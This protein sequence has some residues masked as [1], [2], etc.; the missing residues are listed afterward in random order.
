MPI[1]VKGRTVS[2]VAVVGSGNIGPDIAMHFA[3][4][5]SPWA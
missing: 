4:N 3:Q 5:L 1:T 2:K